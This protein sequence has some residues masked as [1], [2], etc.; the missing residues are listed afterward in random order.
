MS[1]KNVATQRYLTMFRVGYVA[2]LTTIVVLCGYFSV[3]QRTQNNLISEIGIFSRQLA[4]LDT[5]MRVQAMQAERFAEQYKSYADIREFDTFGMTLAEKL[6]HQR[7]RKIDPDIISARNAFDYRTARGRE[8]LAGVELIWSRLPDSLK[9]QILRNARLL[10]PDN[11]FAN[12]RHFVDR[13]ASGAMRT[14]TDLYWTSTKMASLYGTTL[15]P[16]NSEM[17]SQIRIYLAKLSQTA[18]ETLEKYLRITFGALVFL[19]FCV[20]LPIDLLI[21][22]IVGILQRKTIEADKAVV[23]ARAADRAKSEFLATMSHEIRTPMNGVLGMAEL[24]VRTD[25][26][27]RQRTFTNVILKSG[28]ALLEIIN[29]ILDYS[30]IE[31]NQM[32]LDKRSFSIND[33]VEDVATLMSARAAEKDLELIVRLRPSLPARLLGDPSRFRQVITNLLGNAVKFTETGNVMI[34]VDCKELP[35]SENG[36]RVS[37]LVRVSDTGIGIPEEKLKVIFEKFSQVDGSSTRRHEGTGL[38][39][40]IASKLVVLMGGEIKVESKSGEGSVFSFEVQ[41]DVDR[42][43]AAIPSA[44]TSIDDARVLIV[45]DI[46]INRMILTEQLRGWGMDCVAVDNGQMALDFLQHA[47]TGMGIEVDLVILDFQMP[48]MTGGEV[49]RHIRSNPAIA[50]TPILLLSSVDQ[51]TKL[52]AISDLLIEATLTK[53][54][55]NRDLRM[56]SEEIIRLH[57]SKLMSKAAANSAPAQAAATEPEDAAPSAQQASA[58]AAA[59]PTDNLPDASGKILVAEDNPV[60]Q[61]VFQQ[62]LAALGREHVLVEN[63]RNAVAAWK[64]AKPSVILM[65]ISMPEMNGYEATAAIRNIEAEEGL[66]GTVI[67]AVTAHAMQGDED[68]C[69]AAGFDDYLAKPVSVD[70]LDEK[71]SRWIPDVPMDQSAVA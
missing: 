43:A 30:K 20:F 26:D 10:D 50:D 9:T 63:G 5:A 6:E 1:N 23:E 12:H 53:P 38:G 35:E 48:D 15:E 54:T 46:A 68:K 32:V 31:A 57:R 7:N 49:I 2:A 70:K 59:K 13:Q 67:I 29:D 21:H 22:R 34:D 3:V 17:Q 61:I 60:N 14:K 42:E 69:L 71:L 55:R 47:A 45:D 25:L 37:I 11:P 56:A 8:N 28:N 19:G 66:P 36:E 51:A 24:L 39:L 64:K 18:G 62:S 16:S 65:D 52:D 41:M 40:A 27:N 4:S 58:K 33:T 44:T